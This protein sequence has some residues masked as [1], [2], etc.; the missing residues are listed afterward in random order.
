VFKPGQSFSSELHRPTTAGKLELQKI[1]IPDQAEINP[2]YAVANLRASRMGRSRGG[3]RQD[4]PFLPLSFSQPA[5]RV[6]PDDVQADASSRGRRRPDLMV[7]PMG[8]E[9]TTSTVQTSRSP[10]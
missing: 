4:L 2:C 3:T 7:E 10:N 9:P 1:V 5:V 8:F 6:R